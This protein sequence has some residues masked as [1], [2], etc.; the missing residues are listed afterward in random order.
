LEM[1]VEFFKNRPRTQM[2]Y[3]NYDLIDD[4]G[5]PLLGSDYCP[6][7]QI[8]YGSNHIYLPQDPSELC[9]IRNNYIG[10][11]F[12]YRS[13][14]GRLIGD[15][16]RYT[17]TM[18]DYDYWMIIN[19]LFKTEHL[20]KTDILYA[21]RVHG[22]SLTG[23]KVELKIVEN[24]DRLMEFEKL[25]REFYRQKFKIYLIGNHDRLG[26]MR[27]PYEENG[28]SVSQFHIPC[29]NLDME[30]GK[31]VGIWIYSGLE[32]GFM[33]RVREANPHAF[34]VMV[35]LIPEEIPEEDL[36]GKFDAIISLSAKGLEHFQD[37]RWFFSEKIQDALYPILCRANVNLFR[38]EKRFQ[39]L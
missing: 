29:G 12:M 31:A 27:R 36:Q 13:W 15:Y 6:G 11:C 2:V 4:Q 35:H 1:Q 39:I 26:E 37:R 24:T 7:Y 16:D 22:D 23:R 25:R 20:G 32:R 8:P 28:N 33:A 14:V 10:P 30:K 18:E 3:A 21:N 9:V 19:D 38:K 34:F 17:F 5:R